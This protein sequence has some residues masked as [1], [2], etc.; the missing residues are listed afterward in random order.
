MLFAVY[1]TT[2][3]GNDMDVEGVEA[4]VPVLKSLSQLTSL[5]LGG[6]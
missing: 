2:I 6:E 5:D 4:L 1:G 3:P